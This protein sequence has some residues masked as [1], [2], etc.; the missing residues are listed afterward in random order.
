[1]NQVLKNLHYFN[2]LQCALTGINTVDRAFILK[3]FAHTCLR[4][5]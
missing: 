1:M 4:W 5:V 3:L 2:M